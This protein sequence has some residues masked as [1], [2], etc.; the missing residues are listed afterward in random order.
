[1]A[2]RSPPARGLSPFPA[3]QRNGGNGERSTDENRD[4]GDARHASRRV[5]SRANC[6]LIT[7]SSSWI[8]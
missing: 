7:S 6:S 3:E 8:A 1:M 5:G 4:Q 2:V